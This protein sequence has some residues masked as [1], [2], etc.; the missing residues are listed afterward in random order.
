M[1]HLANLFLVINTCPFFQFRRKSRIESIRGTYEAP[2]TVR[3]LRKLYLSAYNEFL[4]C[5]YDYIKV[6]EF[7]CHIYLVGENI[8][9]RFRTLSLT[10]N[11][12][13]LKTYVNSSS[14]NNV[15]ALSLTCIYFLSTATAVYYSQTVSG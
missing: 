7:Y 10:H 2:M 5:K 11:E 6:V 14:S 8:N 1:Q 15:I 12:C 4:N 9:I 3:V 13:T